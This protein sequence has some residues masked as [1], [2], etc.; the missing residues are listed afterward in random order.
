MFLELR[1]SNPKQAHNFTG[2]FW[3][4]N[5]RYGG[6]PP[7]PPPPPPPPDYAAANRAGVLADVQ[8]LGSRKSIENAA[9]FGGRVLAYGVDQKSENRLKDGFK[10]E[11][12]QV[13]TGTRREKIKGNKFRDVPVYET[14]TRYLDAAGNEVAKNDAFAE[15]AVY[16]Q[17]FDEDGKRLATPIEISESEA[18]LDFS[19]VSDLDSARAA[20]QFQRE[21]ADTN[22][23]AQLDLAKKY[24]SEFVTEA[25]NQL[26]NLDP[27]AYDLREQLGKSLADELAAGQSLTPEEERQVT[28]SVRGAQVARGNIY[29]GAPIA[30]EAISRYGAGVARQQQRTANVQSYLGLNPIVA[31]AGGLSALQQ[32][33]VPMRQTPIPQ[34][35]NINPNAGQLGTQFALG[36]FDNQTRQYGAQLDYMSST[37][38]A[39]QQFAS[40]LAWIKG[41]GGLF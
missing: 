12:Y 15:R 10:E 23:R 21:E 30:Q 19:G 25:K 22:A 11:K 8:S 16:Y 37:Y 24:S 34:G 32:G 35:V 20:A 38:A 1:L 31:Q 4:A 36:V 26:R 39:Q 18:I 40:P 27:T 17:R 33:A 6:S 2:L 29:G 41:I 13:Q 28:Q 9:R 5:V 7:S 3:I 14:K